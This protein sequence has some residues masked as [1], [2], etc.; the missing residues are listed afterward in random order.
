MILAHTRAALGTDDRESHLLFIQVA[1]FRNHK[2]TAPLIRRH[3]KAT[4]SSS[5]HHQLRGKYVMV[6]IVK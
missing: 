5:L 4:Q 2:I 3:L 6:F 1:S